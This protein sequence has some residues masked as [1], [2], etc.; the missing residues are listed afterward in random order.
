MLVPLVA[1][2]ASTLVVLVAAGQVPLDELHHTL[3]IT[4]PTLAFAIF[5]ARVAMDVR[6]H[7]RPQFSWRLNP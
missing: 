6:K 2:V 3:H 5:S 4:L 7:G 1:F